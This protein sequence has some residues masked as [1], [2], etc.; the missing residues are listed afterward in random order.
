MLQLQEAA[1]LWLLK[2]RE[3][4]R[5]PL[6][7]MDTLIEDIESLIHAA[8]NCIKQCTIMKLRDGSASETLIRNV[9][10]E[11]S[12]VDSHLSLF[13]GLKSQH[14]QQNFFRTRFNLVVSK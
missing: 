6:S 13:N 12:L 7:V 4:H 1:A 8:I 3:M 11:F 5:L 2:T 9:S 10:D 14:Q